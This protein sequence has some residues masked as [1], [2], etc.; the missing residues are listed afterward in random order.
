MLY[1]KCN[2]HFIGSAFLTVEPSTAVIV[3]G[4]CLLRHQMRA[5]QLCLSADVVFLKL[6]S[7]LSPAQSTTNLNIVIFS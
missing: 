7:T 5:S 1:A 2:T 6:D 3:V 4:A